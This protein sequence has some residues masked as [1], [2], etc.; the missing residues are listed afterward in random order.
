MD[1]TIS[2]QQSQPYFYVLFTGFFS[3]DL[4]Q[5]TWVTFLEIAIGY[6]IGAIAGIGLGYSFGRSRLLAEIFEPIIIALNGIPRTAL[7]PLFIVWLG[8]GLWSKSASYFSLPS[9]STFLR[10][11]PACARWIRN[12]SIW[13]V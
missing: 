11:T 4:L 7:A 1:R 13:Q 6:P 8:I 5:H 10:R 3:G 12:T 2:D 9:S